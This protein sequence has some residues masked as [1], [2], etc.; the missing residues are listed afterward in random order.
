MAN[1]A[2]LGVDP[3]NTAQLEA[4][5]GDAGAYWADNADRFDRTLAA[6][7][8]LF[9][10]AAAITAT[11][12]VLDIGCGNGE[13]TRAAGRTATAGSAVGVDLSARM[14][15]LARRLASVEG[16]SNVEFEQVDAQIHPFA[17]ESFDVAISRTGTMFFG[18]AAAAFANIARS[19]RPGGRLAI[20]VWQGPEPN[21]WLREL[22]GA[23]AAGRDLPQPPLG[24]PGPFAQA[25]PD[26][27][28][29]LLTTAGF[30]DI[31]IAG[32]QA[33]MWFGT[34]PDDAHRFVL[35]LMGWMLQG[36]DEGGKRRALD[37]LRTAV[38]AHHTDAGV[39]LGSGTWTITGVRR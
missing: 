4:W 10:T 1:T 14:I 6:Y 31:A 9:M 23:F 33:P 2:L 8:E 32:R 37:D 11:D 12:R 39:T 28:R 15:E 30:T 36:L 19:L 26:A 34:D 29:A 25:D 24:A 3:S 35:G 7:Q 13:T 5:D 27:T 16:L 38:T 22:G 17:P 21:E 20:L 18:D